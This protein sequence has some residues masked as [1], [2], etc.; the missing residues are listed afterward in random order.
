MVRQQG[1]FCPTIGRSAH[2]SPG[3]PWGNGYCENFTARFRDELLESL[4]SNVTVDWSHRE[5]ARARLRVLVKRILRKY[6]I[7]P[8]LQDTAISTVLQQAEILSSQWA[9]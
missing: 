1:K 7:P 4:K 8:D 5:P 3:S 2:V 6:G 9:S